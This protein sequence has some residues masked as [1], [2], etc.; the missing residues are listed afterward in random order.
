[1]SFVVRNV[2]CFSYLCFFSSALIG[3]AGSIIV[4]TVST[5]NIKD[6]MF[7]VL[8]AKVFGVSEKYF[9]KVRANFR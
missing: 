5:V 9:K 1:V 3:S 7:L 6:Q 4:D 2:F 8:F